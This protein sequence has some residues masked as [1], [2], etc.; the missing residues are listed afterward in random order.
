MGFTSAGRGKGST[1]FFEL[2][3]Y[4]TNSAS[5][6]HESSL[7][8]SHALSSTMAPPEEPIGQPSS[9]KN[10]RRRQS[11][12][13]RIP[14]VNSQK[15]FDFDQLKE[16]SENEVVLNRNDSKSIHSNDSNSSKSSSSKVGIRSYHCNLL[17]EPETSLPFVKN[18]LGM[19]AV[20][21]IKA[22]PHSYDEGNTMYIVRFPLLTLFT[23]C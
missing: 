16:T 13:G 20:L 21:P 15:T 8:V 7:E 2:P 23:N 19:L 3:L 5:M 1:F 6:G 11:L 18:E 10:F 14:V 12:D 9:P 22:K 17:I 4:S